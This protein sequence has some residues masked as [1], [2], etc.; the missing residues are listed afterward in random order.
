[1]STA[2]LWETPAAEAIALRGWQEEAVEGLRRGIRSGKRNQI[3]SAPTGS[4]KTVIASHLI[5]EAR[6]KGRRAVFVCDRINLIDQTSRVFD[7]YGI[8]HG[9]IQG[10]H[11]RSRPWEKIQVASAQTLL[12]RNWPADL[13]LIVVDE[14][15]T[16]YR[17]VAERIG[18]R[19]CVTIGLTATPFTKG[20]GQLYDGV[21]TVRTTHQL[22]EDG[23]LA[24][25]RIFSASEPDMRGAKVS[26]GEWTE[27]EARERSMPIVGDLVT[28]YL[29]HADGQRFICF[30]VDVKHCAEIQRQFLSAGVNCGLY[31][32]K[33]TEA[34]RELMLRDFAD[35]QGHIMGLVSVSALAK[36]FDN[37][38]VSVVILARPLRKSLAEHIQMLGRGLRTDPENPGKVCTILDHAGNCARMWAEQSE[39]F[40]AGAGELDDGRRKEKKKPEAKE[41]EPQKCPAC[42][43]VHRPM[44]M[45][46]SC[47][48]EYPQR[49]EIDHVPGTLNELTGFDA[50][51]TDDRQ[52]F[53]SQ[54]LGYAIERGW[55][56]GAA[57]HK[58]RE[59]YGSWPNGLAKIP[60]MP[61]EQTRNWIR[62]RM[63]AW[64]KARKGVA[65]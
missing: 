51:S 21:V 52:S 1:M 49:R 28:E 34:E 35:P 17:S 39:F 9:V 4:G 41:K 38:S 25:Y 59:R 5:R 33:T 30:G 65:A 62:S 13:D 15:H 43:A 64:A 44:P 46:P 45:C 10:E 20:L 63:I 22:I 6:E 60:E 36:G 31:T 19:D 14:A 8:A 61:S 16:V 54:M 7:R 37:P 40:E 56:E 24:R 26:R 48:H 42:T 11:Q 32:Y 47:G 53:Y 50:G 2:E 55:S 18:R 23:Y 58:Y 57:A 29:R 27:E 3:L 12:R